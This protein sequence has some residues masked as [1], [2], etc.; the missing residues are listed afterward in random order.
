MTEEIFFEGV[1]K[2]KQELLRAA[3]DL[4]SIRGIEYLSVE[5]VLDNTKNDNGTRISRRTFYKYFN[6]SAD[7]V[8]AITEYSKQ[9]E[10]QP[11]YLKLITDFETLSSND[12]LNGYID[13]FFKLFVVDNPRMAGLNLRYL[14]DS[15]FG[16]I[17]D[18]DLEAY[19]NTLANFVEKIFI[20]MNS[21]NPSLHS[22]ML[23]IFLRGLMIEVTSSYRTNKALITHAQLLEI[24]DEIKNLISKLTK[25]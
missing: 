25:V 8:K 24:K 20:D 6:S 14:T 10:I 11:V 9:L 1:P 7:M 4:I 2:K 22:R 19:N 21:T 3:I 23:I 17:F 15:D 16:E 18:L 13:T 5:S 12:K